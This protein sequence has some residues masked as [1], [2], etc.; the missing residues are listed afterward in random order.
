MILGIEIGLFIMG[1]IA[2]VNGKMK[3]SA[4]KVVE[5]TPARLLGV[6]AVLTLPIVFGLGFAY[7]FLVGVNNP[8]GLPQAELDRI[9]I[10]ATIIELVVVALVCITIFAVGFSIGGPPEE[11]RRARRRRRDR[12]YDEEDEDDRPRRRRDEDDEYDADRPSRRRRR[13]EDEDEDDRPRRRRDDADDD[14]DR[15]RRR[16]RDDD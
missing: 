3:F 9:R 13:D 7:G 1:V 16:R 15:P 6:L 4:N 5:G 12:D 2:L 11:E 14:D 8:D 10:N